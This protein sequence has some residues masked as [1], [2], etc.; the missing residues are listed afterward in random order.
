M[1]IF[2]FETFVLYR[3]FYNI[4]ASLE[5][6]RLNL[7]AESN[8]IFLAKFLKDTVQLYSSTIFVYTRVQLYMF[9]VA[10]KRASENN[11]VIAVLS[12]KC[13]KLQNDPVSM[14]Q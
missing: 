8:K 5:A 14:C 9:N 13:P 3:R 4:T 11:F 6:R 7:F 12:T 10:S 2:F 1:F